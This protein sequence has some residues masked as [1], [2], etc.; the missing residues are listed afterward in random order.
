MHG[1]TFCSYFQLYKQLSYYL[2]FFISLLSLLLLASH[3]LLTLLEQPM[4]VRPH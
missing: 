2:S 1:T 4:E 3:V